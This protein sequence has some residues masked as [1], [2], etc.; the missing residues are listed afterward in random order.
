MKDDIF[1]K[2]SP[3]EALTNKELMFCEAKT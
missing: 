1:N 3:N 2:I